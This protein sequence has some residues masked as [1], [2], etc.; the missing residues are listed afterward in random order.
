VLPFA[1]GLRRAPNPYL[2]RAMASSPVFGGR[3]QQQN[4]STTALVRTMPRCIVSTLFATCPSSLLTRISAPT[5]P[6]SQ[7]GLAMSSGT[8]SDGLDRCC[9]NAVRS[10]DAVATASAGSPPPWLQKDDREVLRY[11]AY[12]QEPVY[13][14]GDVNA[15]AFR[16]R[17]FTI[18]Y[19]TSSGAWI[20]WASLLGPR[21][22]LKAHSNTDL[23]LHSS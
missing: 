9:P 1:P 21:K 19:F 23:S 5:S 10:N 14:G 16:I 2:T 17:R 6:K 4:A 12:F 18:C 22:T 13:E 3:G 15:R 11:Y 7:D 8:L 20:C